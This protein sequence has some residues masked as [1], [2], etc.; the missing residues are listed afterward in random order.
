MLR[1]NPIIN[2]L[3]VPQY[4]PQLLRPKEKQI[5]EF[6]KREKWYGMQSPHSLTNPVVNAVFGAPAVQLDGVVGG[7]GHAAVVH[8]DSSRICLDAVGID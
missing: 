8:I 6:V 2:E 4:V 5:Q 3:L 7:V 1:W